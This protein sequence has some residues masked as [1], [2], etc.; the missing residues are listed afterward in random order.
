M[1][2]ITNID[3]SELKKAAEVGSKNIDSYEYYIG[4][5]MAVVAL[6]L[7]YAALKTKQQSDR[8]ADILLRHK[9]T[10]EL[11]STVGWEHLQMVQRD[12]SAR[13]G[14]P[15]NL[16]AHNPNRL[17][18]VIDASQDNNADKNLSLSPQ[19]VLRLDV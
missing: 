14:I 6:V 1:H 9:H 11:Y 5:A 2:F 15:A 7:G 17:F 16:S 19:D 8:Y 12:S 3:F 4:L 18:V 13:A 10:Q